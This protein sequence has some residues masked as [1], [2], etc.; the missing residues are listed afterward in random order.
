VFSGHNTYF[1]WGLEQAPRVD[2]AVAIVLGGRRA[3][4]TQVFAEV[5]QVAIYR[6]GYCMPWRD[7]MPIHV[8]HG[9]RV[10]L[11]EVWPRLKHFE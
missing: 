7:E 9:P 4:L 8:A 10:R 3:D 6:C 2:P 5:E 1:L 11:A